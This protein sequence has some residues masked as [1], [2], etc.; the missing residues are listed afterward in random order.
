MPEAG[1][2]LFYPTLNGRESS[3]WCGSTLDSPYAGGVKTSPR[4]GLHKAYQTTRSSSEHR[5]LTALNG[6]VL[7]LA[8]AH[9]LPLQVA[10]WYMCCALVLPLGAAIG[11]HEVPTPP[12][13]MILLQF[14]GCRTTAAHHPFH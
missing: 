14:A 9:W 4:G 1:G 12:L 8:L 7:L 13:F 6:I 10:L 2:G 5:C 11:S 3:P